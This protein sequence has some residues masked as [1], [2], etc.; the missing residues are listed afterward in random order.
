MTPPKLHTCSQVEDIT[1]LK[2]TQKWMVERL[3]KF[4]NKL[5]TMDQKQTQ[6]HEE[7]I[8][9]FGTMK[10]YVDKRY[11]KKEVFQVAVAVLSTMAVILG[12]LAYVFNK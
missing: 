1:T 9:M 8:S 3:D 10:E 6:R 11:V 12:I 2:V 4:E 5:D 7:I